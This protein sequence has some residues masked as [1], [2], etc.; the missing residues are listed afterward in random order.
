[1]RQLPPDNQ[2]DGDN[3][4]AVDAVMIQRA[5]QSGRKMSGVVR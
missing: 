5:N 3:S 4:N 1:V 2:A